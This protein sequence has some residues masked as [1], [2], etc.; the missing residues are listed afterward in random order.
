M[1]TTCRIEH[2]DE[3]G[4]PILVTERHDA[5]AI[6][7][8]GF[9]AIVTA[10]LPPFLGA[11]TNETELEQLNMIAVTRDAGMG[12]LLMM[13]PTMFKLRRD[14]PRLWI[15]FYVADWTLGVMQWA[16]KND[17]QLSIYPMTDYSEER[18]V[19][20]VNA[21]WFVERQ[22][23][24]LQATIDRIALFAR[25]F[26]IELSP[27]EKR[28]RLQTP[29][30][31]K[32]ATGIRPDKSN[33]PIVAL[34]LESAA[35]HRAPTPALAIR[36]GKALLKRGARLILLGRCAP[37]PEVHDA[38]C[39]NGQDV[40]IVAGQALTSVAS[41]VEWDVDALVCGDTGL[42][43]LAGA[44]GTPF[45]ALFGAIPPPTRLQGYKNCVSFSA[46]QL[47]CVPCLERPAHWACQPYPECMDALPADAIADRAME[48]AE[49]RFRQRN[50]PSIG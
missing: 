26:G 10:I 38:L 42:F 23:H 5:I 44:T 29:K 24:E 22:P 20:T 3:L 32:G 4:A 40:E 47:A 35:P 16:A 7:D 43:H 19:K 14:F 46:K 21:S 8:D 41:M 39:K 50:G 28:W 17:E 45:V 13:M 12:D 27:I 33:R 2:F 48:L 6:Q 36:I 1:E 49:R 37:E 25:A 9:T 11:L 30:E 18:Y 31:A 15:H 34:G